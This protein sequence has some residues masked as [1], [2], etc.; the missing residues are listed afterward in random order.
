MGY[1]DS[2]VALNTH[3]LRTAAGRWPLIVSIDET[4]DHHPV[5]RPVLSHWDLKSNNRS[6]LLSLVLLPLCSPSTVHEFVQLKLL[7]EAPSAALPDGSTSLVL[8]LFQLSSQSARLLVV[9]V[10]DSQEEEGEEDGIAD[11]IEPWE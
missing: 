6:A 1:S 10:G 4:G 3:N 9:V 11:G 7:S 5:S 2:R 8:R